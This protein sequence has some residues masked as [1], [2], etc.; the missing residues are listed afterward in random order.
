MFCDPNYQNP[1]NPFGFT[2][3]PYSIRRRCLYGKDTHDYVFEYGN[4]FWNSY[5]NENKFLLLEF[6]DAH[7]G[8]G[9]VITNID[10]KL[11]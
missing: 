2:R 5:Q 9:E 3:G 8:T 1:S 10:Q 7:E 11:A 4:L 6:I